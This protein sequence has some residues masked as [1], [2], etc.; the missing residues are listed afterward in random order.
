M[1]AHSVKVL[2]IS[3]VIVKETVRDSIEV[4]SHGVESV[5]DA[6]E[7]EQSEVVCWKEQKGA[8]GV[9][10]KVVDAVSAMLE[11]VC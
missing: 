8:R 2:W 10:C 4:S 6:A 5:G 11:E 7:D 9:V 3:E 1:W